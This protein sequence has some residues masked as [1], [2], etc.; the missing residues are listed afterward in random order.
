MKR[1]QLRLELTHVMTYYSC[2]SC[3][4]SLPFASSGILLIRCDAG[5]SSECE[6]S[7]SICSAME[8]LGGLNVKDCNAGNGLKGEVPSWNGGES[9]GEVKAP[10][11]TSP[12]DEV[13]A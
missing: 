3:C 6:R 10:T 1:C 9:D 12:E 2:G 5:C 13:A 4:P 11:G 8:V 7:M